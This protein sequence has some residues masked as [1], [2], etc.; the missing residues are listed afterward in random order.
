MDFK[1]A[2]AGEYTATS[3]L[4]LPTTDSTQVVG[5][6]YSADAILTLEFVNLTYSTGWQVN[7]LAHD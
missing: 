2:L 4:N 7:V 3:T 5:I 1:L 6:G